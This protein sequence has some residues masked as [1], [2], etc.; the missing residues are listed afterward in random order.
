M[1][2]LPFLLRYSIQTQI[3]ESS[4]MLQRVPDPLKVGPTVLG[5][6]YTAPRTLSPEI[7]VPDSGSLHFSVWKN[8]LYLFTQGIL[9]L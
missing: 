5:A 4:M 6:P 3:A 9:R 1:T 2:I 7:F 8:G